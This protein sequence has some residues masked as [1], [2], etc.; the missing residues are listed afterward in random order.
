M[1]GGFSTS[2]E[3]L[4]LPIP[5]GVMQSQ[6]FSASLSLFSAAQSVKKPLYSLILF[7]I[8]LL[9]AI[10]LM[11][12][13]AE[14]AAPYIRL[15][16]PETQAD[17]AFIVD[18]AANNRILVLGTDGNI[19]TMSPSGDEIITITDDASTT[20]V[21]HQQPTWSP[22]GKYIAWT[23]ILSDQGNTQ[24]ALQIGD[25]LGQQRRELALPFAPFYYY[26]SPD[27]ERLAYLS[28]WVYR[29]MGA[30]ALRIVE[31][32]EDEISSK[33]L[34]LGQPS[35]FSWAPDSRQLLTHIGNQR[36][37]I[38]SIDGTNT[39]LSEES[40]GFSAP[41]WVANGAGITYAVNQGNQQALVLSDLEG[42]QI[43]EITTYSNQIIFSVSS[44]SRYFAYSTED[45]ASIQNSASGLYVVD[46][47]SMQ[48][49]EVSSEPGIGFIWSPDGEKLAY[50][51]LEEVEGKTAV[52]W[53]VWRAADSSV[54]Q[55]D[56]FIPSRTF[57][58]NYLPFF[59]QYVQSMTLWSPDSSAFVYAGNGS[60]GGSSIWVQ[61]LAEEKAEE[62]GEGVFAAWSPK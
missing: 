46:I 24:S 27:S 60:S 28:N 30:L 53:Y 10:G 48:T 50:M 55:Y 7:A 4:R 21:V 9:F 58:Q 32:S 39:P 12:C 45:P 3:L 11:G 52:R 44:T 5:R 13:T 54:Q 56:T 43:Q 23:K 47:D 36:T 49:Q 61:Q 40:G 34:A 38:R 19:V 18:T 20:K 31:V 59:D 41:Q 62:V 51:V 14:N 15:V 1:V 6:N 37:S 17:K 57:L 35:Y 33:T 2:S 29:N 8:F 22:D 42:S 25:H 16:D 26:W